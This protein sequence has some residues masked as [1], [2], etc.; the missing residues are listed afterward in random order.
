M[1]PY[2]AYMDPMG[3]NHDHHDRLHPERPEKNDGK[4]WFLTAPPVTEKDTPGLPMS[5]Y[6][7][8]P[9]RTLYIP[10]PDCCC[11]LGKG[12]GGHKWPF[13][14]K[15]TRGRR[16][17]AGSFARNET[18]AHFKCSSLPPQLE[19]GNVGSGHPAV[20]LSTVSEPQT[21][22]PPRA[23]KGIGLPKSQPSI[24][25]I[26]K[27]LINRVQPCPRQPGVT[28]LVLSPAISRTHGITR[29]VGG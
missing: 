15:A 28:M 5:F 14:R 23:L 1:L 27:N 6:V 22:R 3:I 2:I 10:F 16:Q 12:V 29:K 25:H 24:L 13:P 20:Q 26:Y 11:H 17:T 21:V 4:P 9:A 8:C 7:T 19:A 18:C